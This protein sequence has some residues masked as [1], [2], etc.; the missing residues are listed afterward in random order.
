MERAAAKLRHTDTEGA[1]ETHMFIHFLLVYKN[2]L[3]VLSEREGAEI[4]QQ[5]HCEERLLIAM[6][7][8]TAM[9]VMIR[10]GLFNSG[11]A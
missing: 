1:G 6:R 11:L 2:V 10:C 9:G 7:F 5:S 8:V 3:I 4:G